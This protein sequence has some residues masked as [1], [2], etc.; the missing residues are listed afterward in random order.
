MLEYFAIFTKTGLVLY[1][2]TFTKF[3]NGARNLVNELI[4]NVLAEER[5]AQAQSANIDSFVFK[6][7]ID[8]K[9]DL[10]FLVFRLKVLRI[11]LV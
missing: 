1:S 10:I 7:L 3:Q 5:Q 11:T 8:N 9:L 4:C 2:K 6:W